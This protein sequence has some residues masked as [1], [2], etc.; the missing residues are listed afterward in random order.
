ML[1]NFR[2]EN[3]ILIEKWDKNGAYSDRL[4]D[5]QLNF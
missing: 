5:N 1:F 3:H 4:Y 2:D